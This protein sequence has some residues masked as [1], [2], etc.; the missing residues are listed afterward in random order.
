[1]TNFF[2]I[3]IF[4]KKYLFSP[5]IL[6]S[7]I[8]EQDVLWI[9]FWF[10]LVFTKNIHENSV[11]KFLLGWSFLIKWCQRVYTYLSFVPT[12]FCLPCTWFNH[13]AIWPNGETCFILILNFPKWFRQNQI[14]QSF[15]CSLTY[16][17]IPSQGQLV[18]SA[19]N[20]FKLMT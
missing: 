12:T 6:T 10:H 7:S 16:Q 5:R 8:D 13:W 1:M 14:R 3:F 9:R 15:S 11:G 19:A 17:N 20:S 2:H 4:H 18:L